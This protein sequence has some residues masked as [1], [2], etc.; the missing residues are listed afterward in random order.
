MSAQILWVRHGQSTWNAA[1]RMQ[2]HT[3]H[4]TLTDLGRSQAAASARRLM[5]YEPKL[6]LTSPLVRAQETADIIGDVLGLTP[7]VEQQLIEMGLDEDLID[8]QNRAT[9]FL[10][11]LL[12]DGIVVAVSH[13]DFIPIALL[14]QAG[15]PLD[16]WPG[17]ALANGQISMVDPLTG[18]IVIPA[19]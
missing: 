12:T 7:V 17:G 3:A 15:L 1:G 9:Q 2:G 10:A 4:P 13:G 18:A 5:A 11:N 6:L 8:V 16:A 19:D 14:M